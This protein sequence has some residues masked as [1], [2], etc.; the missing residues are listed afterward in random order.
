MEY[1]YVRYEAAMEY[2]NN[3]EIYTAEARHEKD[4]RKNNFFCIADQL[5]SVTQYISGQLLQ[6]CNITRHFALQQYHGVW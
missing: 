6:Q 4:I 5:G 2:A 1:L 3:M